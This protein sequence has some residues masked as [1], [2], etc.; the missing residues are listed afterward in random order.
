MMKR[1]PNGTWRNTREAIVVSEALQRARW[2]EAETIHLKRMG[3]SFDAIAEQISRVGRGQAQALVEIPAG[4]TFPPDYAITRQ[5]CHKAFRRGIAREPALEVEEMRKLDTA[6]AE[7]MFMNLQPGIRKGHPRA[8]EIGLKLLDHS[9]KIH[10]YAAPQKHELT[11]KDGQ[12]LTLV[13][14][15]KEMG[16]IPEED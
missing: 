16:P 13:Q 5:A 14:L 1:Q 8:I 7:E 12:P 2:L 4:V 11:G 9:A 6:R 10:A 15:L 3:F